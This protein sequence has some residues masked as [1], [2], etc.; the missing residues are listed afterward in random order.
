MYI[1][2]VQIGSLNATGNIVSSTAPLTIGGNRVWGEFFNGA[3]DDVRI[4]NR[5]LSASEIQSLMNTIVP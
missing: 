5:A 2:G 3:I 4:Y 1:N